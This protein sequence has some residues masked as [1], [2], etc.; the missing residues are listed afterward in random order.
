MDAWV[1]EVLR[2]GYRIPFLT[3]PPLSSHPMPLESYAPSSVRGLALE[4]EIDKLQEVE[5]VERVPAPEPGFY[6]RLF[7][8]LKASG[9]WRPVIDLKKL[10][11]HIKKTR[12][13]MET[14]QLVLSAVRRND[15]MI[16]IDLKDAYLQVPIHPESRKFLRFSTTTGTF[17]FKT[18][19]FGLSTAPQVF[20]RVMAPV[21]TILHSMGIR[22]MR[23]L[24]DWLVLA[25]S[26]EECLRAREIKENLCLELGIM[27]N[28]EKSSLTPAQETKYLGMIINSV[29]LRASPSIERQKNLLALIEEFLSSRAQPASL[30]RKLLGHLSS[31]NQL[32]RGSRLRMRSLQSNLRNQWDFRNERAQIT[33]DQQSREDLL[34][35]T[36]NE[37]LSRG[38]SLQMLPPDLSLWT[39]ASDKGW[40]AHLSNQ[41]TSGPWTN[42]E[43]LL[44]IN[45]RELRAIKLGLR[46]FKDLV[47]DK[48]VALFS[49]NISAIAYLKNQGGT[50]SQN[51]NREAQEILRWSEANGVILLPQFLL[52][53][54]NVIADSLSR[55]NEVQGAEWTLCQQVVDRLTKIWPATIDLFATSLNYRLPVYFAPFQDPM[56]LGTDALLQN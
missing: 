21:S 43:K 11:K 34:W 55:P 31:M 2:E 18:L 15:W 16:S 51:L 24:D 3:E 54:Q 28:L 33:W 10:N 4:K 19:C 13:R 17:Q 37:R 45:L 53:S 44:S 8:V 35:W 42:E 25:S 38:H 27:I 47:Q 1:V 6:S 7:V 22:L 39:D 40:G 41:F 14:V 30:W 36:K 32:V 56:S 48:V 23:Y 46:E 49:D 5:A 29:T 20:T 50:M 12:F 26:K 52:G 9:S